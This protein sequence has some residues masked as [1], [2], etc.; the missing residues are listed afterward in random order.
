MNA[1]AAVHDNPLGLDG[2]EF[3]EFTGPDPD[4]LAALFAAM[5]FT[6]LGNHKSK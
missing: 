4:A 5:G 2:F 3:V 6:H 1:A